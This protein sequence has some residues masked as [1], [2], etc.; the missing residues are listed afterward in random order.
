ME[1][2]FLLVTCGKTNHL[3]SVMSEPEK[4]VPANGG[5]RNGKV[6]ESSEES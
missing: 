5:E 3:N 4:Y 2:S 1:A 6:D